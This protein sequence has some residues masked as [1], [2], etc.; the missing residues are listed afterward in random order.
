[1]Q[2]L[3][4]LYSVLERRDEVFEF[5]NAI[6]E[7]S[8][9]IAVAGCILNVLSSFS[10]CEGANSARSTL[11]PMCDLAPF[12]RDFGPHDFSCRTDLDQKKAENFSRNTVVAKR[13]P[14]QVIHVDR[15]RNDNLAPRSRVFI[16]NL[17]GYATLVHTHSSPYRFV[18]PT[19]R[20][21]KRVRVDEALMAPA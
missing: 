16:V 6:E 5:Q 19:G 3:E 17:G 12:R 9:M 15:R 18:I 11:Q 1:M 4:R 13:L 7:I 20:K 21:R 10:Q 2:K 8:D 14:G